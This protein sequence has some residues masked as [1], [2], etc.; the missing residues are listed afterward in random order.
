LHGFLLT[1]QVKLGVKVMQTGT[2]HQTISWLLALNHW[3]TQKE[4]EDHRAHLAFDNSAALALISRPSL[5]RRVAKELPGIGWGRSG[6]VARHFRSVVDMVC[7]PQKEWEDIDGIGK[8]TASK[9]VKHLEGDE[10]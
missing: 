8:T 3:W 10:R 1:L 9:V 6:A 5:V 7:A 4:W 2:L